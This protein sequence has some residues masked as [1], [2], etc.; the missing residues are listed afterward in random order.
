MDAVAVLAGHV[1]AMAAQAHQSETRMGAA[2]GLV[3]R[4]H[5]DRFPAVASALS[6]IS[7]NGGAD[8]AFRFGLERILDGI[9]VL[10][11]GR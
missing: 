2:I 9:Q 3:L 7:A 8:Q 4:E 1:R 6:D 11:S 5:A 10:I